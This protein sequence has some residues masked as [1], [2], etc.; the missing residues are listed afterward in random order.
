MRFLKLFE[1]D[2][3][4]CCDDNLAR[5]GTDVTDHSW[6][7]DGKPKSCRICELL[8]EFPCR[9]GCYGPEGG[10]FTD[11]ITRGKKPSS[12]LSALKETIARIMVV[13]ASINLRLRGYL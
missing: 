3:W 10:V 12:V 4:V 8:Y 9:P 5:C 1:L 6:L 7:V 13:P 11:Y 2:H